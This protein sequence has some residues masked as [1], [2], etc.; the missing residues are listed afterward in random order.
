MGNLLVGFVLLMFALAGGGAMALVLMTHRVEGEYFDSSKIRLHYTMKGEGE[1]V[2]LLHGF[3]VNGDINWRWPGI[4]DLVSK[5]FR[6][7]TLD[8]RG[9]GLSGKP[10]DPRQYGL[11]MVRDVTRL[12]DHLQIGKAHVVGYSMGGF[13]ALKMA[14]IDPER[15]I[16]VSALGA[17]WE[18]PDD[19]VLGEA[20]PRLENSLRSGRAIGP[21]SGYLESA[22]E[23]P[24]RLQTCWV[25]LMTGYFNDREALAAM[26]E[27]FP[28]LA[29][30][31]EEM[32]NIPLPI[33]S[34]VGSR[35]PLKVCADAMV[36][37]ISDHTY[38]VVEDTEHIRTLMRGETRDTLRG[39]LLR[40]KGESIEKRGDVKL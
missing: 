11:E 7:I 25:K 28:E 40:H 29:L 2:V 9:H 3:A 18:R 14:V 4:I 24:G 31:K 1:P 6:V 21:L 16:T 13:I 35:D 33:C 20:L 36:G 10:H 32:Q 22:T 37:L 15:L 5:D 39:F 17:G 8:L 27:G 23:K 26:M 30:T 12:L 19:R 34:I 38:V